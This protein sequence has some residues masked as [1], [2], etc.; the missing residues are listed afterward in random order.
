MGEDEIKC[1]GRVLRKLFTEEKL[2][3]F[4][5]YSFEIEK[6]KQTTQPNV[7]LSKHNREGNRIMPNVNRRGDVNSTNGEEIHQDK[8]FCNMEGQGK[9]S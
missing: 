3:L 7:N 5:C 8:R 6:A 9:I 2:V 4:Y 1:N